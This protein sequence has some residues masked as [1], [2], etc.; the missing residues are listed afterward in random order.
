M[1]DHDSQRIS[2]SMIP[3]DLHKQSNSSLLDS[4]SYQMHDII[5]KMRTS[6]SL[7]DIDGIQLE[8]NRLKRQMDSMTDHIKSMFSCLCIRYAH[9]P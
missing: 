6:Q 5:E 8:M 2:P 9:L 3:I 1:N 4:Q 7:D